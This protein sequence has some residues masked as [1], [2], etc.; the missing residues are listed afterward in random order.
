M[1][2]ISLLLIAA[3]AAALSACQSTGSALQS[4]TDLTAAQKLSDGLAQSIG[5]CWFADTETA[6]SDYIYTPEIIGG[7]PR[8]LVAPKGDPGGRPALVVEARSGTA[9]DVYGPLAASTLGPRI[10]ADIDRWRSGGTACGS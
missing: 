1:T 5:R 9:V 7:R 10:T 2:R 8:I 6:F 3:G 4:A